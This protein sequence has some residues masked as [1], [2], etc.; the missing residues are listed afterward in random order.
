MDPRLR[1]DDAWW[2]TYPTEYVR[3][4]TRDAPSSLWPLHLRVSPTPAAMSDVD[5][6]I[7]QN[8]LPEHR[9]VVAVLREIMRDAAPD[10]RLQMS[11]GLPMWK[12]HGDPA[13]LSPSQQGI[14][15]GFPY[16]ARF[17][18]LHGVLKGKAKHARHLTYRWAED[19]D[20]AI[21]WSY[22]AQAV[23]GDA[24]TAERTTPSA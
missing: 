19:V 8:V 7:E 6:F 16:G 22:V 3:C 23:T 4:Q 5:A 13:Y 18:D 14:T 20:E 17:A 21:L 12:A 10:A 9:D 2:S 1:G 15:F 11:Y 24:L